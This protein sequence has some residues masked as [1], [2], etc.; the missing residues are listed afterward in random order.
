MADPGQLTSTAA[1]F[2]TTVGSNSTLSDMGGN[3]SQEVLTG[4]DVWNSWYRPVHGYAAPIVCIFGV[5]ANALNFFVL[6][7]K[8]MLSPT[9]VILSGLAVS[10]GLTMAAYFPYAIL[11][12]HMFDSRPSPLAN[13]RFLL[14]Y[15]IFSV[16]VH[17]I[18]I[19]LTV[20][21]AL[22]RYIFIRNPRHGAKLCSIQRAKLTILIVSVVTTIACV[23]NSVSYKFTDYTENNVTSWYIDVKKDT[24]AAIFIKNLNFWT[25]ALLVKLLPCFL[26]TI[27]SVCLVKTMK[28]AEKRRKKLLNK[29][30]KADDDNKRQGKTNR[31]TRMLLIVVALFLLTEIPQGILQL[32]SGVI[33]GFF[34][35]VY[36]PLGD[37]M[38]ILALINNGINFVLYCTMS[39]QFRDTFIKIFLKD[40][41]KGGEKRTALVQT[42]ATRDS[43]V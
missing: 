37:L 21:L 7:S 33:D 19:W 28:D 20:S 29:T 31:T 26:L 17:S 18:S 6:T 35:N 8:N 30:K 43:D 3:A 11:N 4:L 23:P 41:L 40:M 16:V 25:Q 36:S 42:Q 15:A 13:A 34:I 22:F 39:K 14:F 9:N 1:Y 5:V 32:L 24:S 38:D 12:Y 27:L 2:N 10:D